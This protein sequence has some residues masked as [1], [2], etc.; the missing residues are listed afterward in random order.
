[1]IQLKLT[2]FNL[3]NSQK[4]PTF[5]FERMNTN[6]KVNLKFVL[7]FVFSFS[8]TLFRKELQLFSKNTTLRL[9]NRKH[10][11]KMKTFWSSPIELLYGW[12]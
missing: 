3:A 2:I 7:N 5:K 4:K 8:I 1:M 6:R 9:H 10:K 11:T 12:I